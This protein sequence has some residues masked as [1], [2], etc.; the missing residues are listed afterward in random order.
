MT[1]EP[2]DLIFYPVTPKSVWSARLVA[3]GQ[4]LIGKDKSE[5]QYS[6]VTLFDRDEYQ[7]ESV[8]PWSKR[9]KID[10][11]RPYE[12]W[13]MHGITHSNRQRIMCWA[14]DHL[15]VLYD[16]LYILSF[17]L[18]RIHGEEVCCTFV[19]DAYK[20][21]ALHMPADRPDSIIDSGIFFK[22]SEYNP[23]KRRDYERHRS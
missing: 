13:R 8:W 2:G 12:I 10:T 16:M 6:H 20:S 15:G 4:L 17:G 18:L 11:S 21:A 22:V 5:V 7:L 23:T 14:Y 3:I 19:R 9:S 1:P